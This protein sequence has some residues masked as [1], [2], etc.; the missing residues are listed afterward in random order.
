MECQAKLTKEYGRDY[1]KPCTF[2]EFLEASSASM[3]KGKR[4]PANM[5]NNIRETVRKFEEEEK[6]KKKTDDETFDHVSKYYDENY[7]NE[8]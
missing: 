5:F 1:W 7:Y 3:Q 4:K 6:N 2:Q 8:Y